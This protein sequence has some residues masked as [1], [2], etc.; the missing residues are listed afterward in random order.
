MDTVAQTF[1]VGYRAVGNLLEIIVDD[2][3]SIGRKGVGKFKF[4]GLDALD[5]LERFKM[6]G[7][8]SGDDAH[9]GMDKVAYLLD[10][11]HVLGTHFH[12]E[13]FVVGLEVF[14]D[15]SHDA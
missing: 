4:G 5:G 11:A 6:L 14:A 2:G 9:G 13:H 1:G 15:C 12:D 10:V 3:D 7:A 8:D